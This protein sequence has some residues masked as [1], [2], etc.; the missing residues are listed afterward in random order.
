MRSLRPD[1]KR[2]TAHWKNGF[3]WRQQEAKLNELPQFKTKVTVDGF[4]DVD[5][6]FIH[7]KSGTAGAIPLLFVHG[8]KPHLTTLCT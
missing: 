1:I 2:L 6:H 7:Q 5:M 4:D 8:C 3:D